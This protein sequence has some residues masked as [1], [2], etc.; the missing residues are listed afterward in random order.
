MR[1][2]IIG[3]IEQQAIVAARA[4]ERRLDAAIC[5]LTLRADARHRG[6]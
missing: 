1:V 2:G 6:K 4:H 5:R 3:R